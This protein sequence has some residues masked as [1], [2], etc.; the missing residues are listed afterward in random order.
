MR[1]LGLSVATAALLFSGVASA[2]TELLN[3]S[4]DPTRELYQQYNAAF[5]K[6]WK[7]TTG[8]DITIKNSHGGSGKQARSVIDGL[9]AD[10]VTLALAGDID[11]LNLNQQLIDPKWQARLPDNSTPYTSTIVFL[12][13]KGNP[14][15][16]KDWNDLVK[17]GVEVITPN[18]KTS[19]GARWNF[20]AAWAYA[21][22]QPGGNDETALKFVT[23]LYRHAPVLDTGARG[24]T[25]SFVQRQLG[26]VLLAWENEAYLSLQEQGGDQLEIV[27]PS[28]SILAEP[29]V[30]VVDKVVERKGTQKQAE[31]YLQYLYSDEAQR[32]IG[33][34]F[35]R[36]RN[37]KIA[38]EFKDQFAPV[39]LVTID[40]DFG[41]WKAAQ[42]KFFNDGGV[43]D[44]IF[45]E[46]NK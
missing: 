27:T 1:R 43:F 12:V 11:A 10:V 42:D 37:A 22:A 40:K 31:A 7:A 6:H 32:I 20:L 38:E 26:D 45:K 17:P 46:I 21:K 13:R 24:A 25:I 2:A 33:K 4:Y 14:K 30:A 36:P 9:Q 41:G 3:V 39:N 34:N 8:E 16:I 28:L 5:I 19:G 29:P 23:E 18:P 35:Y 44:D 15:Q